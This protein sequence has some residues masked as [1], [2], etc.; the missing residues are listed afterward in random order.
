MGCFS[1]KCLKCGRGIRSSSFSGEKTHLFLLKDGKVIQK[2]TGE[3]DSYGRVFID[4]T[5]RKDVKHSLRESQQWKQIEP[6]T[7]E[8][9]DKVSRIGDEHT[10]WHQVCNLMHDE[11]NI[12]NGIAA[13]HVRCFKKGDKEPT[14]RSVSDPDQGW[15]GVK[16]IVKNYDP[17]KEHRA[18]ALKSKIWRLENSMSDDLAFIEYFLEASKK[19]DKKEMDK[20]EET[21][22]KR[23]SDKKRQVAKLKKELASLGL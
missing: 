16:R 12:S 13:I 15:G 14:I 23:A 1:F 20:Y 11:N 9:I 8:E 4:G 3:Y 2:M 17:V 6:F 7:A 22:K 18:E 19:G 10:I 5:Q 21:L